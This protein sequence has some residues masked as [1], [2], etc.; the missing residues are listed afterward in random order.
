MAC[1]VRLPIKWATREKRIEIREKRE[2]KSEEESEERRERR[3]QGEQGE[4]TRERCST[5]TGMACLMRLPIKGER[6]EKRIGRREK[7]TGRREKR[8]ERR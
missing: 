6:R 7:R 8:A 5:M 3:E 2:D 4:E 1:L